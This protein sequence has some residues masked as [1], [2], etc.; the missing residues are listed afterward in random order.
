[1]AMG[2]GM[3]WEQAALQAK[4]DIGPCEAL[5]Q[6]IAESH[7][8]GPL[9]DLPSSLSLARRCKAWGS[10]LDRRLLSKTGIPECQWKR[11]GGRLDLPRRLHSP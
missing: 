4:D 1:M 6:A 3:S 7:V 2:P 10:T 9:L 8:L 11:C 5:I